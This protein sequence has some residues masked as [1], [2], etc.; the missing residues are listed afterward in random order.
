MNTGNHIR[1]LLMDLDGTLA[2]TAPDLASALNALLHEEGRAPLPYASVRPFVSYGAPRLV[3]LG[4]GEALPADEFERLRQ[5]FLD[6]YER[7]L[8]RETKLFPGFAD[9]LDAIESRGGRWGVVTNKPGWLTLPLIRALGLDQRA[10]SIVSGDTTPRRKPHPD[11]LLH[12]AGEMAADTATC[13]YVGDAERDIQAG[14]AAGMFTV[15]V[16]WGYIPD[17]EDPDAWN[18]HQVIDHPMD[19]LDLF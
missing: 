18:A 19:L 16:R 14:R 17:D 6:H 1:T 15:A 7:V 4:F 13:V 5:G 11:P 12:A 10:A 8:C 3:R 2:D 9:V